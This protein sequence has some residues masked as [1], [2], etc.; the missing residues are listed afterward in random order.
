M[1]TL[2]DWIR[3]GD[4][5]RRPL[6]VSQELHESDS[7]IIVGGGLSGLSIAFRI[8]SARPDLPIKLLEKSNRLGGVIKTWRQ[9]EWVC[10]ISV[11]A[12]R[13]HPSFWRLVD[14]LGM[15]DSFNPSRESASSRWVILQ[16]GKHRLSSSTIFKDI[17]TSDPNLNFNWLRNFC[18]SFIFFINV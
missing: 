2:E 6:L 18:C 14:D 1:Y 16:G 3:H 13:P 15:E 11:N 7:L 12:V 8:G 4:E 10:D 17:S 5:L 9:G